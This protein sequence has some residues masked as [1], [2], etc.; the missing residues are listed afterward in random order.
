MKPAPSA[1]D[2]ARNPLVRIG[3]LSRRLGI[4]TQ[5]LRNWERRYGLLD[6]HRGPNGYR[7]YS[8]ADEARARLMIAALERG[9][10][11][12]EAAQSVL[13]QPVSVGTPQ[14]PGDDVLAARRA[15]L[16][17][18]LDAF[19]EIAAHAVLDR[20]LAAYQIDTVLGKV[21]VPYLHELGERWERGE[22]EV[23]REHFASRFLEGRLL[24]L[25]RGWLQGGGSLTCVLACA[26]REQ[27]T[28]ST[29]VFGIALRERGWR[30]AY[31]GADT[32]VSGVRKMMDELNATAAVITSADLALFS[33]VS[34][35]LTQLSKDHTLYIGGAGA[36]P[37]I[38]E[39]CS[40]SYLTDGPVEGA[41]E[42]AATAQ[43]AR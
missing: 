29:I 23:H 43:P 9:L 20:L 14:A 2:A 39:V 27:H 8:A 18:A 41:Q 11:P 28:L 3:E 37:A 36:G 24:G 42:I 40:C 21:I 38:A 6:P 34:D 30:I 19:D 7:L 4:Q 25:G 17:A 16:A 10:A 15:E 35:E 5:V 32:P 13:T 26:P 31:L 22:V 12:A 1:K 33:A